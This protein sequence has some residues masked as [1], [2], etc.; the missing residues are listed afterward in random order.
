MVRI[1]LMYKVLRTVSGINA[2][3]LKVS[4]CPWA[5]ESLRELLNPFL[6][7]VIGY[8]NY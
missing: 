8:P 6:V 1:N 7:S 5:A 3:S 4:Q 2:C